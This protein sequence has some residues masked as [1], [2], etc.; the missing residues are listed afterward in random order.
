MKT[1]K[2]I[3][4]L[5]AVLM[6]GI[7][8]PL[9]SQAISTLLFGI[10]AWMPDS[11][12]NTKPNGNLATNWGKIK[13]S[14]VKL[15]RYG[16]TTADVNQPTHSQYLKI[17]DSIRARGM[18]PIL[19]V[20]YNNTND[21][22]VGRVLV[23][24]INV[25]MGKKVK[26]WSIGNEP[27]KY[28]G[29]NYAPKFAKYIK[30]FSIAMKQVDPTISIVGPDFSY[31]PGDPF[32]H[33]SVVIDSL[34]LYGGPYSI[35]DLIPAGHGGA[36]GKGYIDVFATHQYD[37]GGGGLKSRS[38][39]INTMVANK[40]QTQFTRDTVGFSHINRATA[41]A[42]SSRPTQPVTA[43]ITEANICTQSGPPATDV[44]GYVQA[45]SFFAGQHWC[46]MMS[47]AMFYKIQS[48][49]FWSST[50]GSE[51]GYLTSAANGVKKST[52]Y[53]MEQMGKWFSG[54]YYLGTD[55]SSGTGNSKSFKTFASKDANHIAIMIMNEDTS[56]KADKYYSIGLNNTYT[57]STATRVK[58]NMGL[59]KSYS[60]TIKSASTTLLIFN[61]A[62][63]IAYKY[64]YQLTDASNPFKSVWAAS[65]PATMYTVNAGADQSVCCSGCTKTFTATISPSGGS[66]TYQW[67]KNGTLMSGETNST[68]VVTGS[69]NTTYA[70]KVVVSA[71]GGCTTSDEALLIIGNGA[72]CYGP[73]LRLAVASNSTVTSAATSEIRSL[74]PNPT[75]NQVSIFYNI[76]KGNNQ[77]ELKIM[78]Y[79]GQLIAKYQINQEAEKLEIDCSNLSSGIYFTSLLEN[80]N[81]VSTKKLVI[82]K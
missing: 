51:M 49:N 18:E 57:L 35:V 22:A 32:D 67:Y 46:E 54:T 58:F 72:P 16:G 15:V 17:I 74:V 68:Y 11:V 36:T 69:S 41:L 81:A 52:Y 26:Y 39:Y 37:N 64:R 19:Q 77:Y 6:G 65:S 30:K 3:I 45:S 76:Q 7:Y 33:L 20:S 4:I 38:Y 40:S 5:S 24:Y 71:T 56:S 80:G 70:V 47:W 25:T 43:M 73:V 27:D 61:C 82:V 9:K 48:I 2:I 34:L 53:H 8:L 31:T 12:G 79:A 63:D 62:G 60:D 44:F 42:T 59:S 14:N 55:D 29:S 66:P 13:Y 28:P 78:N 1:K 75:E 23:K 10:N 50:E 21:S